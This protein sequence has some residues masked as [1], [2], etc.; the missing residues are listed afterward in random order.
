MNEII[1]HF[2]AGKIAPSSGERFGKVHNPSTGEEI[3][4]VQ[5]ANH[6]DV[7]HAVSAAVTAQRGWANTSQAGRLQVIFR[8]RQ[9]LIDNAEELAEIIGRENG[10]TLQDAHGEL[11]RAIEA[12]EF[13][14]N[15]AHVSKGEYSRNV[16]GGIDTYSI[17]V[18]VGVV[19]AIAPFNFPV[20]VPLKMTAMAIAVGNAI[21]LKPSEK[22]PSGSM[23]LARLWKEAGLPDG[24][25]NVVHGDKEVVASLIE[26][27]DV[28]VIS[29]VGSTPVGEYVY[30]HGTAHNKRVAA[31]TGG[32]NHMVV[33][34]DADLE[35][36]AEGFVTAG[37]GSA[38]QRCMA[39]SLV[40]AVG[41]DTA[42]RLIS[43]MK[44]KINALQVGAFNNPKSDFGA[45]ISGESKRG[46]E[47]A[48][49]QCIRDGADVVCD[50][51]GVKVSGHDNGFYL[52]PTFLDRVRPDM[53]FY[54][55]EVFGPARAV[56]RVE[57]F[58]E[59]M[60]LVNHHQYGNGAVIYTRDGRSA[61][62]FVAEADAGGLGV[63]VP[64]PVAVGY[65]D[66][67]GFRRSRFGDA[68]LFGPNA[69]RFFTKVK[70]VCERWPEEKLE[71][72]SQSLA[73][74]KNT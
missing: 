20:M 61:A 35:A 50:G 2:I 54:K 21:V 55:E 74:P 22:V 13:A 57:T 15:A 72:S 10:K 1:E 34:P 6:T 51:R 48:I 24:I 42:D 9:L 52:G 32:K 14:T 17:R 33:M 16:G 39:L 43:L 11:G 12:V 25:W 23:A 63:N 44:P 8:L 46:I 29:F 56:I 60:R 7:D 27:E 47:A 64:V 73:F 36:A 26:H 49:D 5:C 68:Q 19:A 4:K 40:I 62:R 69:A 67:G 53:T 66:F 3:A 71:V 30:Q 59:A 28:D 70:T 65:H 45:I 38:S 41:D 37:Y 58:D 31:F 18:P